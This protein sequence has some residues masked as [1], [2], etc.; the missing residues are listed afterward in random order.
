MTTGI[1][2]TA[3]LLALL[4]C[5]TLALGQ[6][7]TPSCRTAL[8]VIDVQNA[9][10][11]SARAL[12]I[13]RVRIA[14]KTAE[15]AATA[16]VVGI[17]V[18]FVIDVSMRGQYSEWGLSLVEPLEVNEGD[19]LVEKRY[20][21]GFVRTSLKAEL[22]E[23]EVT[24]LMISGFA[25]DECVRATVEGALWSGFEVIIIEDGHSGG[26]GGRTAAEMNESWRA[27]GLQVIA[28]T[29]LDMAAL[30]AAGESENGEPKAE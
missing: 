30:C 15:I 23:L 5:G 26:D 17:P 24:T 4:V 14:N 11:A 25:S 13:D 27:R 21:N 1:K 12:T 22:Q 3:T 18:V 29:A 20:K 16:R 28:S 19:L 2:A 8:L 10:A 6:V 7:Q 9:W